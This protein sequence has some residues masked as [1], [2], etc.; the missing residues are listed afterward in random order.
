LPDAIILIKVKRY[1]LCKLF[2]GEN[3]RFANQPE[4]IA[5]SP[6]NLCMQ[7]LFGTAISF[8]YLQLHQAG[9]P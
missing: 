3:I 8:Y 6:D 1:R 4:G 9:P 2:G 7:V 5:D